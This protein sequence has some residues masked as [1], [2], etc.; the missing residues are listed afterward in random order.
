MHAADLALLAL[1][2]AVAGA[3][4]AVAGGGT[5]LSFPAAL[6]VGLPPVVANA[7][8]AVALFPGQLASAW[9]YRRELGRDRAVVAALLPSA[10]LGGVAGSL[11]LLVTP[12][13]W[14]DA[15]VPVLVLAATGL[16]LVQ[17]LR[18]P[19]ASVA[20]SATAPWRL[21]RPLVLAHLGHFAAGV[22]GGYF[23]AGLGILLLALYGWL[24]GRDLH[25]MNGVK[26][27]LSAVVNSAACVAFVI[28][29]VIEPVPAVAMA[30]GAIAG[31]LFG[32]AGARRVRAALVRW[33]VVGIGLAIGV[34]LAWQRLGP[35]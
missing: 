25:R 27:V 2:G 28:A 23:G 26:T 12:A 13:A 15:A 21:P 8:N 17:N 3:V 11:L 22:Y 20:A 16:L 10:L 6:A 30:L 34:A 9:A 29:G 31:G 4:N 24:G 7:T 18:R 32:A 33:V 1:A 5:L 19:A 35:A 14:F